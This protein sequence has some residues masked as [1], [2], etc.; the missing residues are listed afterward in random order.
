MFTCLSRGEIKT[1]RNLSKATD[2][3]LRA[4]E[5]TLGDWDNSSAAADV[6]AEI[7]RRLEMPNDGD[8]IASLQEMLHSETWSIAAEWHGFEHKH[9]A[10]IITQFLCPHGCGTDCNSYHWKWVCPSKPVQG[11]LCT[12]IQCKELWSLCGWRCPSANLEEGD[13]MRPGLRRR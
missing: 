11:C 4:L 9:V 12:G 6:C 5:M 1:L 7:A 8:E 10:E 2:A 13:A 3:E